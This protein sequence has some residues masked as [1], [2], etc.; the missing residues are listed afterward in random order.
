MSKTK[1][2]ICESLGLVCEPT[3]EMSV[4]GEVSTYRII[5]D[6]YKAEKIEALFRSAPV[7]HGTYSSNGIVQGLTVAKY[8]SDTHLY[9]VFGS[10]LEKDNVEK[11]LQDLSNFADLTMGEQFKLID[12]A[13]KLVKP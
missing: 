8:E 3:I 6:V 7:Y 11:V 1:Y 5:S 2:P 4:D 13:K 9:R 10:P 12:R